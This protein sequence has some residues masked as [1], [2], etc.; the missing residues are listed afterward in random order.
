MVLSCLSDGSRF[1]QFLL[2]LLTFV[3]YLR[4]KSFY[5]I[6]INISENDHEQTYL[7]FAVSG[8]CGATHQ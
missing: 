6:E 4:Y 5:S 1:I 8:L 2:K 7:N 3:L